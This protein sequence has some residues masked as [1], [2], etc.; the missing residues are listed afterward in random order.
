MAA[1]AKTITVLGINDVHGAIDRLPLLLGYVEHLRAM[2]RADKGDVVLVDAGDIFQGTL[3]S[4]LGEGEVVVDAYNV[5]GVDAATLGNHEFDF[6]PVGPKVTPA[7]P[8]DDARGAIKA[9]MAQ[10]KFPFV[11]AN[12]VDKASGEAVTWP[13][14][15]PSVIVEKSGVKIGFIGIATEST[16]YTTMPANFA[17][18]AISDPAEAIIAQAAAL[19]ARG[20][21]VLVV[22]AHMGS[23]CKDLHSP[24]NHASCDNDGELIKV[25][26][27]L[28]AGVVDVIVGGHTHAGMAHQINDIAVIESFASGRAFGRV[29]V[30]VSGDKVT[31]VKIFP[32][33]DLCAGDKAANDNKPTCISGWYEGTPIASDA[34][35]NDVIAPATRDA[36]AL[37]ST[38]VGVVLADQFT[39]SYGNESPLGNLFAELM[40]TM[41]PKANAALTNAGGVRAELPAGELTYGSLY[42]ANPFDNRVTVV[43]LNGAQ[44][45]K[46]VRGNLTRKSGTYLWAGF[47]T[48]ATCLRG[49]L[50]LTLRWPSG[51]AVGDADPVRLVT[52]DFLASGSVFRRLNLP[53]D[54]V[55]MTDKIIREEMVAALKRKGGTLSAKQYFDPKKPRM[56]LPMP[57]PVKC[58]ADVVEKGTELDD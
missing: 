57:R 11:S 31:S 42:E 46:L 29:D 52:S 44:L 13:G 34:R 40:L 58:G 56:A 36:K 51:K 5:M 25:V 10:A 8:A 22:L 15:A 17:D 39:R 28:P 21:V 50:A 35:V 4:N 53:Q 41:V 6:G 9:R 49:E 23:A 27:R 33:H 26:K 20:A 54:H 3:E 30:R 24:H 43:L 18:V 38:P 48:E 19:R 32:P 1:E 37:R 14:L 45:K 2:R 7:S 12:I 55:I 47:S 16:P